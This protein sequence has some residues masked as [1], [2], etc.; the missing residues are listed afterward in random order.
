MGLTRFR[1]SSPRMIGPTTS[2]ALAQ[3]LIR[4]RIRCG[5]PQYFHPQLGPGRLGSQFVGRSRSL[6]A[7]AMLN[8]QP[9]DRLRI[10]H[11][12]RVPGTEF[13]G[14]P[15]GIIGPVRGTIRAERALRLKSDC[16]SLTH[17]LSG[18]PRKRG[19]L[20]R[21]FDV[22]HDLAQFAYKHRTEEC[23][24]AVPNHSGILSASAKRDFLW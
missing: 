24:L 23:A 19:N 1:I 11:S 7:L 15:S 2:S 5:S 8:G 18:L 22:K 12:A 21:S 14:V 6:C 17:Q 20:G 10:A 16:R 13:V 3:Q 4:A 9:A